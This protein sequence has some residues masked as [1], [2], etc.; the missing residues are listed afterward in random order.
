MRKLGYRLLR[1]VVVAVAAWAGYVLLAPYRL[2]WVVLPAALAVLVIESV[3]LWL[4]ARRR[5]LYSREE[6]WLAAA[7]DPARRPKAI[8]E[9]REAITAMGP[10]AR[11]SRPQRADLFRTRLLLVE[12][13][14]A[15]GKKDEALATIASVEGE[16]LDA[17]EAGLAHHARAK[18][19]LRAGDAQAALDGLAKRAPRTGDAE[20]DARLELLEAAAKVELGQAEDAMAT[21]TRVRKAA[22]DDA[23]L[24]TEARLVRA[25]AL[26][27][28]GRRDEAVGILRTLDDDVVESLAQWGNPR[29]RSLASA[30]REGSG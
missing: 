7:L 13:L 20:L 17:L 19:H 21:A 26:D 16:G 23:D 10:T 3:V 12:L 9:I 5:A 30:S 27:A 6:A 4:R 29:V 1:I 24:A 15:D 14:D 22:G 28:L 18:V 8:R 25:A 2:G 11:M